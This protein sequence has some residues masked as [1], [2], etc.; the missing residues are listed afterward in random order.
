MSALIFSLKTFKEHYESLKSDQT[1]KVRYTEWLTFLVIPI[2]V[3]VF[4]YCNKV[5][6]ES[7]ISE[8][9]T[10]LALFTGFLLN[11]NILLV[12]FI[13]KPQTNTTTTAASELRVRAIKSLYYNI[14][15][16]IYLSVFS[17]IL[18][19]IFY[20]EFDVILS[21][22]LAFLLSFFALTLFMILNRI[23]ILFEKELN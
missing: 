4:V 22:V 2:G 12:N 14:S 16:A 11:I 23:T 1:K 20:F 21:S 9:I 13:K 7:R 19:P 17:I 5:D 18:M 3:T 6:F 15:F 10:A 8:L